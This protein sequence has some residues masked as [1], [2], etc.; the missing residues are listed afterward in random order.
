[1][2]P[3]FAAL[4]AARPEVQPEVKAKADRLK[5][6]AAKG[7]KADDGVLSGLV[8]G[9]ADLVP[10]ATR[11]VVSA[12]ASPMLQGIAGPVTKQMLEMLSR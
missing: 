3:V 8:R 4:A 1:M 10:G 12:F 9:L 2:R 7:D 11:A 5:A 6:E